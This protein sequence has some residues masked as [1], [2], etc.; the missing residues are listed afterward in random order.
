MT[1]SHLSHAAAA[2]LITFLSACGAADEPAGAP[3]DA[4][5]TAEPLAFAI[6]TGGIENHFFQRGPVAAH[7]VAASGPSP[8]VIFAFPA[9]NTGAG[10][11]FEP[12][13]AD[14]R[15]A[16][17]GPILEAAG[18]G[19]MRGVS[20][21]VRVSAPAIRLRGAVMGS[22]RALRQ[23]AA[24]GTVP[25]G[26]EHDIAPRGAGLVLSRT[27][28]DGRCVTLAVAPLGRA[29]VT[30][31]AAG[32]IVAEA[33]RGDR[34]LSLRFTALTDEPPLDP[35]PAD[36]LLDA[37]A[38]RDPESRAALSFLATRQALLAGSWRFLTYFGRDTLITL[39]LLAPV[40]QPAAIEA[41]LGS[42]I[43]RLG[44]EGQV[45]HEEA[46]GEWAVVEN[47]ARGR[48]P[49]APA[50][51]YGMVDDDFLLAPALARY[52]LDTAEGQ[53]RAEA[54]LARRTPSGLSYREAARRNLGRVL[55]LAAPFASSGA[56]RDLVALRPGASAGNWRD[57]E[58]GLGGGRV[59]YDVNTA[60]V[61]AALRA[62]ARL[63]DGP[64][65]AADRAGE[66]RSL[67]D[68]YH[69][70]SLFRVEI[71]EAEARARVI[72]QAEA[73]GLDPAPALSSIDGPVTFDA[74]ALG[75]SGAPVPVM[76][77]DVGFR[78]LYG[79]PTSDE[80]V[81][82]AR[83]VFAPYP[84]GLLTP[85]GVLVASA[86]FAA[87][88]AL[89][90]EFTTRDYHGTVVWSWQQA[91]LAAGI[92]RQLARADLDPEARAALKDAE[93]ALWDV[94]GR[95]RAAGVQTAELWSYAVAGGQFRLVPFGQGRGDVDESNAV[96]L[97]ST[98]YL[99]VRPSWSPR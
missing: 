21:V 72:A 83:R 15:L 1:T 78:W 46:V 80:I 12:P 87:D 76:S 66:A 82:D 57:S 5:P 25:P 8:R 37:A 59:P 84:A 39:Q 53:A 56:A 35:I 36:D 45:A 97:W 9:G 29:R 94:I 18:E 89:R 44:P 81:R 60:L 99:A 48:R 51:D 55:A 58:H 92:D 31:D 2:A 63:F 28:F 65:R 74:V 68:R 95:D 85:I 54:F 96:Q 11:W 71:P 19:A 30:L 3:A 10:L 47:R 88:P 27:M 77:T 6:D 52:L 86:T 24:D 26:F 64:L 34:D 61:P 17:E 69:A 7:V 41:G 42:V 49:G 23:Y 75:A 79:A 70:A 13:A 22:I 32:R 90:A 20:A 16:I 62:A 98:V 73:E 4:P 43:D 38:A 91:L 93:V 14:A 33:P 50:L 67:A 40:L